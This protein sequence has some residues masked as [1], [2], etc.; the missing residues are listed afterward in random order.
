MGVRDMRDKHQW[1]SY[2]LMIVIALCLFGVCTPG[3]GAPALDA[4][5]AQWMRQYAAKNHAERIDAIHALS[6]LADPR[7]NVTL[8]AVLQAENNRELRALIF[9]TFR[10]RDDPHAIEPLVAYLDAHR[11]DRDARD[12]VAA[13]CGGTLV[14]TSSGRPDDTPITLG[15]RLHT[16][17]DKLQL[18]DFDSATFT[19]YNNTRNAVIVTS[20]CSLTNGGAAELPLTRHRVRQCG[21]GV[22]ARRSVRCECQL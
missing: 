20:L 17:T 16:A 22:Y 7:A 4:D 12:T 1:Q 15:I 21:A 18:G 14:C 2:P 8:I 13:L 6:D 3:H 5:T 9:A 19:L 10:Q 11:H